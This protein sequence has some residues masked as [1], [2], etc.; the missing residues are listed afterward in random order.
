MVPILKRPSF[1]YPFFKGILAIQT[2][3]KAGAYL[4]IKIH[5]MEIVFILC[6]CSGKVVINV[7]YVLYF[8]Y[9]VERG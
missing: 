3:N 4:G 6:F 9:K 5:F 8:T 7:F 2:A 1:F